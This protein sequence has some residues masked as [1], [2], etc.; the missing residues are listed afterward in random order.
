MRLLLPG[1][2]QLEPDDLLELYDPGEKVV[3]RGGFV[4]SAD[5]AV[6]ADG[7]SR[8]LQ[9]PADQLAYASLRAVADAVVVGAGTARAE[10]Y[11]PVR[12][13]RA[14]AAWRAA[15]RRAPAPLVLVTRG[16]DLDPLAR[17]F[18]GDVPTLVVTCAAAR[19]SAALRRVADVVIAGDDDVDLPALV[20]ALHA[21]GLTR[22][23]CEGGPTLLTALLGAGLVDE[24]CLTLSPLLIGTA[25]T[26]LTMTLPVP[27]RLQLRHLVD[28]G[29]GS[30]L[31]R[32]AII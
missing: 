14:A 32:Y 18:T 25:P 16:A 2:R 22:L 6:A 13:R 5:G 17:C 31:A 24:L 3:L 10:D 29:D 15:H 28:G 1:Q 19:P 26:L 20:A 27:V 11:G 4:L 23:L 7:S 12:H 30:L 8:P 21:R 9:T